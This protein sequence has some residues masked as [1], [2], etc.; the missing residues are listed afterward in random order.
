MITRVLFVLTKPE[1]GGAQAHVLALLEG[2]DKGRYTLDLFTARN[3]VLI[4]RFCNIPGVRVHRSVFLDR[5]LSP[6]K[7]VLALLELIYYMKINSIDVVHT[8]S[9]KAGVLGRV[10][11]WLAGVKLI[12]HT[13]HGWSFHDHQPKL[14]FS[15]CVL[16]ERWC[17]R[18]THVLIVVSTR[19]QEQGWLLGIRPL[20]HYIV[21]RCGI[22]HEDYQNDDARRQKARKKLAI[23]PECLV[24]GTVACFKPQ[25]NPLAFLRLAVGIKKEIRK[26]KFLMVGDG[27][28]RKKIS[29]FLCAHRLDSDVILTGWHED[30]PDMLAAMDVFVLTSLWEGL[31]V[32]VF[33]AM[34]AGIPVVVTDTGGIRDL[35]IPGKTGYLVDP[36]NDH[37]MLEKV[38]LLLK[39]DELRRGLSAQ[40]MSKVH[41]QEFSIKATI[42]C[43]QQVY[44]GVFER[45]GTC[46]DS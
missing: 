46:P 12:V 24:I 34:S 3:G 22:R 40:A 35:I 14:F 20:G 43:V 42:R 28:M 4:Q 38:L 23:A 25:K 10:A 45:I 18:F 33:E 16:L 21:I 27:S 7:D 41:E 39:H 31:P 15:L 8:H 13:V 26:V 5:S 29:S 32:V 30:V 37:K 2:V 11:A 1:L 36:D 9:S 6:V 17:A 19:E 44:D